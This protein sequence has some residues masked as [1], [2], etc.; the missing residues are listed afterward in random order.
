M[1]LSTVRKSARNVHQM[2][3]DV[4]GRGESTLIIPRSILH[5]QLKVESQ[6]AEFVW[7]ASS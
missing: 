4:E 7:V 2:S 3:Y 1:R 6:H 5:D